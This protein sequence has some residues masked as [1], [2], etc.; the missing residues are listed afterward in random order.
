M[1]IAGVYK[2]E[3]QQLSASLHLLPLSTLVR[4]SLTNCDIVSGQNLDPQAAWKISF[5]QD[6]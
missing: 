5:T 4:S 6:L 1:R 3:R 2:V